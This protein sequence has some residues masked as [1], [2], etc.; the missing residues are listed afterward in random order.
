MII[1]GL[2]SWEMNEQS[3]SISPSTQKAEVQDY[4]QLYI[5]IK[6]SPKI[7]ETLSQKT[8]EPFSLWKDNSPH[9]SQKDMECGP[10][11]PPTAVLGLWSL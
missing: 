5:Q 4:Y 2:G 8:R 7:H 11:G 10:R 9:S 1:L 6:V 3:L